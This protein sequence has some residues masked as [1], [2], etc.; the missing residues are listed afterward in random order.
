[1]F[2]DFRRS[3]T[4]KTTEH[5]LRKFF[6]GQLGI[7]ITTQSLLPIY[8]VKGSQNTFQMA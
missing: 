3:K 4:F 6:W 5:R 1:M 2:N 8:R 7:E